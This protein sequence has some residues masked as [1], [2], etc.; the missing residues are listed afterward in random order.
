VA[1]IV[2]DSALVELPNA[3]SFELKFKKVRRKARSIA[4]W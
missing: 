3:T 2:G 1:E 4:Q